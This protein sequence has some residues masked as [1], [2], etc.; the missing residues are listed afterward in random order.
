[1]IKL[2]NVSK[3]YQLGE[4]KVEAVNKVSLHIKAGEYCGILGSSGSGKSTLM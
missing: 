4:D 1:M 2:Q 3:I